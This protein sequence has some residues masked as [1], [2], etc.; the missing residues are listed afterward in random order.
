MG[1]GREG[2]GGCK[3]NLLRYGP[4]SEVGKTRG[5]SYCEPTVLFNLPL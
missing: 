1:A 3:F 4:V 2:R 5:E